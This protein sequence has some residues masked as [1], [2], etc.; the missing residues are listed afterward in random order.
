M[1]THLRMLSYAFSLSLPAL[2]AS[3]PLSLGIFSLLLSISG[4]HFPYV[5]ILGHQ[6]P[7]DYLIPD[8]KKKRTSF[9]RA[10]ETIPERPWIDP[11][12]PSLMGSTWFSL[13]KPCFLTLFFSPSATQSLSP[14]PPSRTP[15]CSGHGFS[16]KKLSRIIFSTG[17]SGSRF[18]HI[19]PHGSQFQPC[20][21]D[22]R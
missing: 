17:H 20:S 15:L 5:N 8:K 16:A 14:A 6:Q 3:L 1:L 9:P 12:W 22:W 19:F 21:T 10:P 18:I 13:Y 11:A 7:Q 2:L 4:K